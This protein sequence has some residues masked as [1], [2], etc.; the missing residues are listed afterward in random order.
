MCVSFL[1]TQ[2]NHPHDCSDYTAKTNFTNYTARLRA[3][4]ATSAVLKGHAGL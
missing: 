4:Y 1:T 3:A 2:T